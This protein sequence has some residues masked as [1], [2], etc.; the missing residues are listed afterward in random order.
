MFTV[1]FELR[2]SITLPRRSGSRIDADL[3]TALK[4]SNEVACITVARQSPEDVGFREVFLSVDGK[5]V[6]ILR[7]GDTITH[8]LAAGPHKI[9][10][11]NTLFWKTRDVVL[12]P[13]EHA[14]FRAINRAGWGTFGFM[15]FLGASPVYLTFEREQDPC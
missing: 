13:G 14:R 5:D 2:D 10:A 9:Q 7:Y 15:V 12:K 1:I 4:R 11:H 8:E 3:T 6:G